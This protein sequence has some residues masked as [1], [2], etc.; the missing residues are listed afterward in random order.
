MGWGLPNKMAWTVRFCALLLLFTVLNYMGT[1]LYVRALGLT[2]VKPF[3][4][5]ALAILLI[6]GR[7]SLWSVVITGT[8]GGMLAKQF[9]PYFTPFDT[10]F[11]P[12]VV[13]GALLAVDYLTR[14]FVSEKLDFRAWKQLVGFIAIAA[15]VSMV[16]GAIFAE[17]RGP[18]GGA[19]FTA[20]FRAWFIPTTLSYVIFTPVIVLIATTSRRVL[21]S[22]WRNLAGS[23]ALLAFTIATTFL[24]TPVPMLFLVPLALLI[25]TMAAEI[26]G[27][28]LG[29]VFTQLVYSVAIVAGDGPTGLDELPLGIQLQLAQ[30]F[31]GVLIAI[32]LPV[33]AAVTERTK[34]R[35]N[36]AAALSREEKINLALR[37]SERRYREMAEREQSA[38]KAKSEFLANMSHELRTPLN[39]I[40]GFSEVIKAELYGP[41]GHDKYREYADD[42][43]RSGAHLLDLINDVLDLSKID[44]GKMEIKETRFEVA[45]LVDEAV[46]LL[47]DKARGRCAMATEPMD[48]LPA[49]TADKRLIKQILLNLL[50][51]AVKFTPQGGIVRVS[52]ECLADG[53]LA[54]HVS[55][56]G[57]GM[58]PAEMDV[59]FS[60][61]GQVDSK[62]ARENH[63]TGLGL[64]ISR[65][66]AELHGG[67]LTAHS[68]KGTGTVMTVRLPSSRVE[69]PAL[70][71]AQAI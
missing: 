42:V 28:A 6:W 7:S 14:R 70:M 49:I 61:Y 15:I 55:D 33:A 39:A 31:I 8:L 56:T 34:L 9:F 36:L 44:A 41:L 29:L 30:G 48:I 51:N 71:L 58:T 37:E 13:T 43:H 27:V 65:A 68:T 22:N 59:A 46:L 12:C 17:S 35:D 18:F 32:L 53:G 20:N 63:G 11:S 69:T 16:S 1:A 45:T 64:P 5:V 19:V 26:E 38:S 10:I 40:L 21:R 67:T 66:L 4:G 52:A 57:V 23:L 25:V 2:S 3:S 24:P 60:H 47:C 50:S 54:I 62:I